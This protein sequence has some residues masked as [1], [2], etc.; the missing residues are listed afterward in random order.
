MRYQQLEVNLNVVDGTA[1]V[2]MNV[3]KTAT[4][5]RED[6]EVEIGDKVFDVY[7]KWSWKRETQKGMTRKMVQ[8]SLSRK[9]HLFTENVQRC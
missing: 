5:F 7:Q 4:M 6:Y 2:Q 3:P 9:T 1:M 8:C